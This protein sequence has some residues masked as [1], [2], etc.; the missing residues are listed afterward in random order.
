MLSESQTFFT[1]KQWLLP[2]KECYRKVFPH[3]KNSFPR[4]AIILSD[5]AAL[6]VFNDENYSAFLARANRIVTNEA[7]RNDLSKTNIHAYLSHFM[8]DKRKRVNK[9]TWPIIKDNWRF[10][11]Q[12][13]LT[14]KITNVPNSSRAINQ[15][16][17]I[18]TNINDPFAFDDDNEL[19]DYDHN[20]MN[21][22]ENIKTDNKRKRWTTSHLNSS[23]IN[24]S[25]IDD[26]EV[27]NKAVSPFKQELQA[28]YNECLTTC[29]KNNGA[30]S[31]SD[32]EHQ[33]KLDNGYHISINS[34]FQRFLSGNLSRHGT[35]TVRAFDNLLLSSHNQRT[36]AMS[37]RR[38]SIVKRTQ[39]EYRLG[40]DL[41]LY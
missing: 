30:F 23:N 5:H 27:L 1:V 9:S 36:N 8:L 7:I 22:N 13:F 32:K 25:I 19:D 14:I 3:K 12:V 33:K 6:Y 16:K 28:I 18:L 38:M 37:E 17:E 40:V 26:E 34:A 21:T 10:I 35:S 31:S 39:L 41:M 11:Y 24:K 20:P 29:I 2:F 4:P 15:S